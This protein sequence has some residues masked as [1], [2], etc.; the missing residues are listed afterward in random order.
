MPGRVIAGRG[1]DGGGRG[2]ER[3]AARTLPPGS[4]TPGLT[5]TNIADPGAVRVAI[6]DAISAVGARSRDVIAVLPDAA[7]RVALLDFDT[8]P[9]KR[10]EADAVVRFRLKKSLPFDVEH[11]ALSC[12]ARPGEGGVLV[13][14]AVI[15]TDVLQEYE[16]VFREAGYNPGVVVPSM[17][18]ALGPVDASQPTLVVKVDMETTTLAIVAR[19]QLSLFRTLENPEGGSLESERLAEDVYA[20]LIFFQDNYGLKVERVRLGG[21]AGAEPLAAALEAQTGARVEELVA[22]T[23]VSGGS[24][25]PATLLAGVVGALAG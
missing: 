20:S 25:V 13:V 22:E 5:G 9:E 4:V 11:A 24:E 7:V 8:L 19:E 18:A 14:A 12:D 1:A 17:L 23:A 16:S 6:A 15:P 21:V 3:V 10:Q 2:V